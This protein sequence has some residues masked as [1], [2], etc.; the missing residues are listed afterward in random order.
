MLVWWHG[1]AH[2]IPVNYD[3]QCNQAESG[4]AVKGGGG[5]SCLDHGRVNVRKVRVLQRS[6]RR[7]ALGGVEL[8]R[9]GQEVNALG[10]ERGHGL[11]DA[12]LR[13]L[14]ERFAAR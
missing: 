2:E 11:L 10:A 7:D 13:P 12:L 1:R 9:L 14:G 3:H 4:G 5:R 6:A 8:Q